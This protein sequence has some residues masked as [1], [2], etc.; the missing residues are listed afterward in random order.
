MAQR[1]LYAACTSGLGDRLLSYAGCWR[2]A[3]AT[4]RQPRL[5]WELNDRCGCPFDRLFET[6]LAMVTGEDMVRLLQTHYAVKTYNAW[7]DR[8]PP[9]YTHV[10]ADG[11]PS[12]DIIVVKSWN[13]PALDNEKDG[14]AL[15]KELRTYLLALRPVPEITAAVEA[16]DLPKDAIGIH[17]RRGDNVER[18]IASRDEDFETIVEGVIGR[19]PDSQF[20]LATDVAA[21]E[22][23]FRQRF[24]GRMLVRAKHGGGRITE[25]G[26]TESLIDLLLLSRTRAILG[27]QHSAFTRTAA[28]WGDRPV[29]IANAENARTHLARSIATLTGH[30]GHSRAG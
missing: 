18:F 23:R 25:A 11:D 20:F 28:L 13:Y 22:L 1:H 21:V 7:L 15:R 3:R 2:I 30:D 10:A 14:P 27:N 29:V 12:Y 9:R 8:P 6:P 26:M 19:C 17:I 16:F 4:G 24:G 5:Y